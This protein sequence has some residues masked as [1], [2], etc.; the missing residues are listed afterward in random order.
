MPG[1][2]A[3]IV[4]LKADWLNVWPLNNAPGENDPDGLGR[5]SASGHAVQ[6]GRLVKK[7]LLAIRDSG[8]T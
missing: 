4:P 1:K 6:C 3:D 2:D 5:R 8:N 7:I